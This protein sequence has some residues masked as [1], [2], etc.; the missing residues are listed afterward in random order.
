MNM[1]P[2]SL[3]ISTRLPSP[4]KPAAPI[5]LFAMLLAL[6][7]AISGTVVL[8]A[9]STFADI[10]SIDR[11]LGPNATAYHA[12][13]EG[14]VEDAATL[15]RSTLATKPGDSTAHQLLCRAFYAQDQFDDAIPQCELAAASQASSQTEASNNQLWLGRAYG[16]KASHAG[17]ISGFTLA[18]KVAASFERAVQFDP[19]N[20]DAIDD[21]GEFY[22][23]APSIVGGGDNKAQ[24]LAGR[25]MQ[26]YPAAAH[27]LLA[28]IAESN[29][30]L[31]TA[32]AELKR[33][34]AVQGGSEAWIDLA[35]FY[36]AHARPDDALAAV[37]SGIAADHAH[38]A[39]LVA[40]ATILTK[41]NRAPDLAERC[42][43][44]YLASHAK[45][46]AAPAFKVHLQLSRLLQARGDTKEASR[47][48][49]AAAAL[50]PAFARSASA[51]QAQGL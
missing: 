29:H 32:E 41:A 42:L 34:V 10:A 13:A 4:S 28:R 22:V 48:Q 35:E 43:R 44:D 23:E 9:E 8:R 21:L 7:I 46:D 50:A 49:E 33:E 20:V 17:W 24:T 14:R 15:L 16:M 51:R 47:E 19:N 3:P 11:T 36:R 6:G 27:H 26:R 45:S 5:R 12:L 39:V 37:K 38:S 25:T 30:D 31:G 40:A 18:R 2:T 1:R